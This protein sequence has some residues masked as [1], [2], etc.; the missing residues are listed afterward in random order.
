MGLELSLGEVQSLPQILLSI[1]LHIL[2]VVVAPS[3]ITL[4][5]LTYSGGIQPV[6][7]GSIEPSQGILLELRTG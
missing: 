3:Y 4:I 6:R 1:P 2:N 7:P 5:T